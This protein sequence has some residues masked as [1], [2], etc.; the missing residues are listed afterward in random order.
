[1]AFFCSG[2]YEL[3]KEV[4]VKLIQMIRNI[5]ISKVSAKYNRTGELQFW[6]SLD[7]FYGE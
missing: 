7:L 6:Y 2:T 3:T 5:D 4:E 1:M